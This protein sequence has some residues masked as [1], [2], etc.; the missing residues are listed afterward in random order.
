MLLFSGDG[1]LLQRGREPS[2]ERR[3]RQHGQGVGLEEERRRHRDQR[4]HGHRDGDDAESRRIQRA[5]QL[6]GR[7]CAH[8]RHTTLLHRGTMSQ[9]FVAPL[10][11]FKDEHKCETICQAFE[12]R[13]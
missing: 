11:F 6:D 10:S 7:H 3:H 9:G 13:C 12:T 5:D 4:A 2:D 8:F 1:S